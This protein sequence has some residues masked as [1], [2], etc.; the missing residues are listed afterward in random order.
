MWEKAD[1]VLVIDDTGVR[2]ALKFVLEVEGL[3]VRLYDDPAV[4]LTDL[5]LACCG[6]L[7][8]DYGM[9]RMNG[10]DLVEVLRARDI[11]IPVI[12]ITAHTDKEL[13]LR[14]AKAGVHRILQ[15][16]ITDGAL[17]AGVLSALGRAP[18]AVD[19]LPS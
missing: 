3:T 7:V 15:M 4:M 10:L 5:D 17:L 18:E 6:C 11:F 14:A 12:M 9:P 8:V 13:S 19:P 1:I 16:P 2:G